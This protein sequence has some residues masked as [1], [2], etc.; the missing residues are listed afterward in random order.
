MP[1]SCNVKYDSENK[2]V[3]SAHDE[4]ILALNMCLSWG[5]NSFVDFFLNSLR[6]CFK[7]VIHYEMRVI[8]CK[9]K[10]PL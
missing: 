4:Y 3:Y 7:I 1:C 5:L 6:D 10:E 8:G 2:C 9:V